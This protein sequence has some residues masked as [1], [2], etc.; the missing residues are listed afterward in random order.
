MIDKIVPLGRG[1]PGRRARRRHGDD[2]R[3]RHRRLPNELIDGADRAGRARPDD[4]QQQRRQRRHRPGRAARGRP[5][6]QD[7][8]QLP[9]PGRLPPLRRA[10]PRR[11]DRARTGAA[12]QP[13]RAHPRRRRRHRRL[14]HA[15]RLRH[16]A[17]QGQG[18][19]RDRRPHYV[20]ESPIHADFALIKAERGDR[21]G[22]LTY[23]KTARNFGPVMAMAARTHGRHGARDRRA[24]RARPRGHRH[25]GHLRAAR[26]EGRPRG[27]AAPAASSRRH[28]HGTYKRWTKRPDGAARRAGHPRRRRR[29][30]RHRPADAGGQPPAGRPR[31]HPAQRERHPRHGPGA[32]RGRGRLRPHQR[33]QAARHA[34]ARAAPTST[35][36]TASR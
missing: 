28:D 25:A 34:A 4:R 1:R 3:L 11:P 22:N 20:L 23:R 13:G 30:P 27:H 29:Q 33:R 16:R 12:G 10:V 5:G 6:A 19:A 32:G 14:L 24:R 15:H 21:W 17:G 9:A 36:P 26:G 31:G 35:T 8:L 18:D 7:H 2:R